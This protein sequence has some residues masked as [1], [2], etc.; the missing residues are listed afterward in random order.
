MSGLLLAIGLG[1]VVSSCGAQ[2]PRHSLRQGQLRAALLEGTSALHTS[3]R[4][5]QSRQELHL[6]SL[7]LEEK[8]DSQSSDKESSKKFSWSDL[9]PRS[10]FISGPRAHK[11]RSVAAWLAIG[12]I[13]SIGSGYVLFKLI[14]LVI[15]YRSNLQG[16]KTRGFGHYMWYSFE[17][18]FIQTYA[19]SAIVLLMMFFGTVLLG[20]LLVGVVMNVNPFQSL[21]LVFS[22]VMDP[23]SAFGLEDD[24]VL[25]YILSATLGIIGVFMLALLLTLMQ[26]SF[27]GSMEKLKKGESAVIEHG[28]VV[29]LGF[30]EQIPTLVQEI[31]HAKASV[32]GTTIVVVSDRHTKGE[33]E[34]AIEDA[35]VK[36]MGSRIVTRCGKLHSRADLQHL[37]VHSAQSVI[38]LPNNDEVLESRDALTLRMLVVLRGQGWPLQGRI[39]AVCSMIRNYKLFQD[40]GG[41]ITDIVMIENFIAKLMTRCSRKAGLSAT[42]NQVFSAGSSDFF[43]NTVPKNLHGVHFREAGS[44]FPGAVPVGMLSPDPDTDK[45][46]SLLRSGAC[47]SGCRLCPDPDLV[48]EEGK[49]L[50]FLATEPAD[51]VACEKPVPQTATAL[52]RLMH[53]P[54]P[55]THRQKEQENILILGWNELI[56]DML[57]QLDQ[58]VGQGTKLFIVADK[59][60][61][62]RQAEIALFQNRWQHT[63]Q[64]LEFVHHVARIASR[65]QFEELQLPFNEISRIFLLSPSQVDRDGRNDAVVLTAI[66]QMR[67]ILLEQGV[68][69]EIAIIPQI[70]DPLSRTM[71]EHLS[72]TDFID[73]SGLLSKVL[74]M[75]SN[76]PRIQLVLNEIISFTGQTKFSMRKLGNYAKEDEAN[77]LSFRQVADL[78]GACGDVAIGW[79]VPFSQTSKAEILAQLGE[80]V[81]FHQT[82]SKICERAHGKECML[83]YELNPADKNT[84]RQWNWEQ[85]RIVVLTTVSAE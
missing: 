51:T 3:Q 76:Q 74:A 5:A 28:H 68:S 12:G 60:V 38:L 46:C 47:T 64:N 33:I 4:Q 41:D 72:V 24:H 8:P 27:N 23:G 15:S 65:F 1:A 39:V 70:T 14:S 36:P 6:Q 22:W 69:K 10:S 73:T 18:W 79:S 40:I 81:E 53:V 17:N 43:I 2:P 62:E 44:Y 34:D 25:A 35:E 30:T 29:I 52:S 63:M 56:V 55:V 82:M 11:F 71:C 45:P 50:V 59:S 48:L 85:D 77:E 78:V 42:L 31:C 9:V 75:I 61:E 80:R 37:A 84:A 21:W 49:E 66:L 13:F 54:S 19:A 26:D 20:A 67:D 32:G 16:F 58:Q 7:R 57:L 83:E